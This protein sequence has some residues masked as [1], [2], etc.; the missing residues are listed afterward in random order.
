MAC[1]LLSDTIQ[2]SGDLWVFD[3]AKIALKLLTYDFTQLHFLFRGEEQF[4]GIGDRQL[5][6]RAGLLGGSKGT[7]K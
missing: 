5:Q 2:I 3:Y 7:N 4:G 6:R 1:D